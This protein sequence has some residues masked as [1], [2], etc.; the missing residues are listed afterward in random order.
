MRSAF[1]RRVVPEPMLRLVLACQ[2]RVPCH[3]AGGAALSGA[4]FAHR[5]SGDVDLFCHTPGEVRTLVQSLPDVARECALQIELARDAGTFVRA[6][7][8]GL[9]RPMDLDLV[10]DQPDLESPGPALEG[11]VVESLLDLR[12]AKLTCLLS[13][14]EPRDLVDLLFLDRHGFPPEQDLASA[15]RKDAG[16]DPGILAWLLGQFPVR[17]LPL[18]L[19]PLTEAELLRFRDELRERFRRIA[20]P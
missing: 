13:R 7:V 12:A 19:D 2:R 5:L 10:H 1:D 4:H 15:C 14:S 8:R 17:P 16:I 3:L 9:P 11:V 20:V 18:M 6:V